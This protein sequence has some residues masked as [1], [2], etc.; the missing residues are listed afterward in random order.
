MPLPTSSLAKICNLVREHLA[1]LGETPSPPDWD[2]TVSIGAP[3]ANLAAVNNRNTLNLFFYRFE[4]FGFDAAAQPG[5]VQWMRVHCV[6]TAFG[7]DEDVDNDQTVDFSAGF[8]ELRMLSQV[9]R[10]F[11]ER[12]VMLIDGDDPGEVWHTQF[13]P[14]PLADEQI[15]QIWS[16]QGDTIYRPSVVYE[17]A[18]APIEPQ[19]LTTQAARVASVGSY[20][21]SDMSRRHAPW[22][23][24]RATLFPPVP[25]VSVDT[26]N[27]QWAPAILLVSGPAGDR[28]ASLTL[29]LEVPEGLGGLADFGS[30]PSVAIW[31]AGDPGLVGDLT[32]VG[33]LL[34]N[35]D[36]DR[37]GG[38]WVEIT[39]LT[40]L[41]A[42]ADRLDVD[43][44]PQPAPDPSATAFTLTQAHWTGIDN[45]NHSWQLQL[46]VERHIAYQPDS[47]QWVVLPHG[48]TDGMRIRSNPLLISL[49]REAP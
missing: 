36:A 44:L 11:Q 32:L 37:S 48:A 1:T 38:R 14:R 28:Q 2:V 34:Q 4:P 46:F 42:D 25:S 5:D 21:D 6:I 27:P 47:G 16:T 15:N 31:I 49:T 13:I 8:N 40:G 12:P 19:T 39:P 35:P 43:N 20:A 45:S 10:L 18:L 41:S 33:Q 3:G 30:F 7:I 24:G 9:M 23:A 29:N 17:I 26:G 22:P